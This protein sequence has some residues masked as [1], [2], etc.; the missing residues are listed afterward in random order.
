MMNGYTL[1][2]VLA[3]L[4][5]NL[6]ILIILLF[7]RNAVDLRP[8]Q[9]A[10][11]ANER[12]FERLERLVRDEIAQNREEFLAA[13]R[14]SRE[15]LS[16]S[17]KGFGDTLHRQLASLIQTN[18]QKLERMRESMEQKVEALKVAVEERLRSIQE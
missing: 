16:A 13:L 18:D 2:A 1:A 6:V 12:S 17:Q 9:D 8:V 4:G 10:F 7:R 14:Q 11:A 3:L 5:V 15:E